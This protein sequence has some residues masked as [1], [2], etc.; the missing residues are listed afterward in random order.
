MSK[1]DIT[2]HKG[3]RSA[4]IHLRLRPEMLEALDNIRSGI[5][6]SDIIEEMIMTYA[7]NVL[8]GK[9]DGDAYEAAQVVAQQIESE[10][11]RQFDDLSDW[12]AEGDYTGRE[13]LQSLID[14]WS[15]VNG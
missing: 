10:M 7:L 6:R 2:P 14:E 12:L 15:E 9:M 11:G 4:S 1:R 3:G 13:T 8:T 5:S